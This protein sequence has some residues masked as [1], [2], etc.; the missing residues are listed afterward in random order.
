[1][2]SYRA[3]GLIPACCYVI[4]IADLFNRLDLNAAIEAD[5][6]GEAGKGISIVADEVTKLA[7]KTA[8]AVSEIASMTEA[9]Q[10]GVE[11]AISAMAAATEKVERGV[12]LSLFGSN[13]LNDIAG[14]VKEL[15]AVMRRIDSATEQV[16]PA[17]KEINRDIEQIATVFKATSV[18][19]A[20]TTQAAEEPVKMSV[21]LEQTTSGFKLS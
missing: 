13:C 17:S 1:M 11:S 5:R 18:I 19:A 21:L 16:S 10:E 15:Q 4:W 8:G 14:C 6:E 7:E 3:H 2:E 9:T 12:E 20:Q